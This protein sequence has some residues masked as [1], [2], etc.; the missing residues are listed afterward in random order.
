MKP[1]PSA[2]PYSRRVVWPATITIALAAAGLA[3]AYYNRTV[4]PKPAV[5]HEGTVTIRDA[6]MPSAIVAAI[7]TET[8]ANLDQRLRAL[9]GNGA[10]RTPREASVER[11]RTEKDAEEAQVQAHQDCVDHFESEARDPR[12]AART[13]QNLRTELGDIKLG[14]AQLAQVEC[15]STTCA[16]TMEWPT[17]SA[18]RPD[19]SKLVLHNYQENCSR[20]LAVPPPDNPEAAYTAVLYLNCTKERMND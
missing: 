12:W 4:R 16:A 5:T 20:E 2:I 19:A 9:E 17:Y 8:L 14:G 18:V 3:L 11:G 1:V 10:T 15:R 6:P 7:D 13:E